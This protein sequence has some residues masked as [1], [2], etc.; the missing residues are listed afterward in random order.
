MCFILINF[1]IIFQFNFLR[2]S[3]LILFKIIEANYFYVY[4]TNFILKIS[5]MICFSHFI[6][7]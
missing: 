1:C 6:V 3:F 4:Q 7:I 2:I 5:R